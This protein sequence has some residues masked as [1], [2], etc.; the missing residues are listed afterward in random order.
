MVLPLCGVVERFVGYR[1][2]YQG[3]RCGRSLYVPQCCCVTLNGF[4]ILAKCLPF[5]PVIKN[6]V[7]CYLVS[8]DLFFPVVLFIICC[9]FRLYTVEDYK[10]SCPQST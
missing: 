8:K 5:L 9:S 4:F 7:N 2:P 3:T 6:V 10:L 1:Y